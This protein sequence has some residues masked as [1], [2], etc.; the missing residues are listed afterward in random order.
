MRTILADLAKKLWKAGAKK[1]ALNVQSL[2]KFL[3]VASHVE[4]IKFQ[5]TDM[6]CLKRAA[7]KLGFKFVKKSTYGWYGKWVKDFHGENAAYK[8][9]V[10]PEDYGKNASYVL[11][12]PGCEGP[13]Y[14]GGSTNYEI[15]IHEVSPGFYAFVWDFYGEGGQKLSSILGENGINL[16]MA[17]MEEFQKSNSTSWQGCSQ[18]SVPSEFQEQIAETQAEVGEKA[19]VFCFVTETYDDSG[20]GGGGGGGGNYGGHSSVDI[21]DD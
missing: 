7:A 14:N 11:T 9:G 6:E 16:V 20:S 21:G 17:Y 19:Q 1:Q 2:V 8:R 15:G 10:N 18:N 12:M 4:A 13:T 5:V 3:K